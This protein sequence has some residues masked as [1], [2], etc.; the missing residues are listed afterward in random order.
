MTAV[1]PR[2]LPSQ[3]L[4]GRLRA[5]G[6][7]LIGAVLL[8]STAFADGRPSV[9]FDTDGYYLMGENAAQAIKRLPAVFMGDHRAMTTPVSDDDQIDVTVMGARSPAFGLFLFVFD[10]LGGVWLVAAV[11]ALIGAWAVYLLWKLATPGV[12]ESER[13]AG[14]EGVP[15]SPRPARAPPWTYLALMAGLTLTSTLPFFATMIMPD[16]FAGVAAA[17]F[18]VLTAFGRR[19]SRLETIGAVLVLAFTYAVHASHMLT[20]LAVMVPAALLYGWFKAPRGEVAR[21]YALVFAA[22][23]LAVVCGKA[24]DGAFAMRTGLTLHRPPFLMARVLADGPGREYLRKV[25]QGPDQPYVICRAKDAPLTRSDDI[26]WEESPLIGAFNAL[27]SPELQLR[28]EAEE[29]AFVKGTVLNDPWGQFTASME[30]WGDQFMRISVHDPLRDPRQFLAN[31]YWKTTRLVD[32]IVSPEQCKPIGP[33]CRPPFDIALT[34]HW[35]E[36]VMVL[37]TLFL[38]WRLSRPDVRADL[39]DRTAPWARPAVPLA[40]TVAILAAILVLNAGVCGV[41][42]GAFSRYQAR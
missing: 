4:F 24:Y 26:L 16:V 7:V 39:A 41:I 12:L 1:S 10:K 19:L 34:K 22:M 9:F 8:M 28:M 23:A 27:K 15:K 18:V 21:G 5:L 3:T 6:C 32:M 14:G 25:C 29:G 17:L 13:V 38:G 30:N 11:Q 36:L 35:H 40:V 31:D 37:S 2:Q 42:S 33:G 20:A